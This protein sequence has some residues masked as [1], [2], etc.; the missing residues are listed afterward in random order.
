M[1]LNQY[2]PDFLMYSFKVEACVRSDNHDWARCPFAHD[3]EKGR[4]RDPRAFQYTSQPCPHT[5]QAR[6]PGRSCPSGDACSNSHSLQEY[7][8]HPERFR[9]QMCKL[10]AACTRPLCFFA[11]RANELRFPETDDTAAAIA[12]ALAPAAP[13]APLVITP[14]PLSALGAAGGA[15]S[16]QPMMI[17]PAAA[18]TDAYLPVDSAAFGG[19]PH[20]A[21]G[22][23]PAGARGAAELLLRRARAAQERGAAALRAYLEAQ[24]AEVQRRAAALDQQRMALDLWAAQLNGGCAGSMPASFDAAPQSPLTVAPREASGSSTTSWVSCGAA[25]AA[26]MMA[27]WGGCSLLDAACGA[28]AALPVW[29][30]AS[31]VLQPGVPLLSLAAGGLGPLF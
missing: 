24:E 18:A 6:H 19:G 22:P 7:W 27:I 17:L 23:A 12:P 5:M 1:N 25:S 30:P 9:T 13:A 4:R 21:A 15:G 14:G 11:H 2:T 10:G 8:L 16:P 29:G 26:P 28:P 31:E 20:S 3:K